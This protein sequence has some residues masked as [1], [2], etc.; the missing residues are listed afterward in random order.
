MVSEQEILNQISELLDTTE[1]L[2]PSDLLEGLPEYDSIAI[3]A[4]MDWYDT[5][6]IQVTPAD[7]EN[8]ITVKDLIDR[9]QKQ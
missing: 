1:S 7:F 5:N 6:G 2:N 9:A 4:L 8:F 3:L